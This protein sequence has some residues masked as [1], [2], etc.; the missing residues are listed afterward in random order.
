MKQHWLKA[1]AALAAV[2]VMAACSD[3][4]KPAAE[5]NAEPEAKKEPAGP[6]QPVS[7]K[8]AYWEMY[9][10]ARGWAADILPL[11]MANIDV[12]EVKSEGGK[13]P[14]WSVVFVSPSRH[15]ARTFSYSVVNS[16][17]NIHKGVSAGGAESW[18]GSTTKSKPFQTSEFAIDS[19]A[20]YKAAYA[21][22]EAWIKKHPDKPVAFSLGAASRFPSPV[23]YVI[24]G[25]TKSGFA[26]FVN[27]TTGAVMK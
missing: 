13:A 12:P 18:S 15:E 24:W 27:A 19:D 26:A 8:T 2:I 7:A 23:W 21:K 25:N 10:P 20:A 3:A 14:M 1:A 22:G 16:G 17:T 11:S 5:T 9:K 6:P 4:P